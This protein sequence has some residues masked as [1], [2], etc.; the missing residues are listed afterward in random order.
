MGNTALAKQVEVAF[1]AAVG[2]ILAC[3]LLGLDPSWVPALLGTIL[4]DLFWDAILGSMAAAIAHGFGRSFRAFG[5]GTA[6]A[7]QVSQWLLAAYLQ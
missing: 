1:A 7:T 4:V 5:I 6:A 3:D 2:I